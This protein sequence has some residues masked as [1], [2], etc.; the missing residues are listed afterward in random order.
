MGDGRFQLADGSRVLDVREVE[1]E[2]RP[3]FREDD[4]RLWVSQGDGGGVDLEE[5]VF[6]MFGDGQMEGDC[7]IVDCFFQ[8]DLV[9]VE[10]G[11]VVLA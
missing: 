2:G 1:D 8:Q 11:L 3:H 9:D 4:V 10:E 5:T 7:Q 6:D